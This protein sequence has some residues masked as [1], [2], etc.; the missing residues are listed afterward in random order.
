[1][2][3]PVQNRCDQTFPQIF[4]L[5]DGQS[6]PWQNLLLPSLQLVY[7]A[8]GSAF[9]II[10]LLCNGVFRVIHLNLFYTQKGVFC[11]NLLPFS[12]LIMTCSVCHCNQKHDLLKTLSFSDVNQMFN[13]FLFVCLFCGGSSWDSEPFP[14]LQTGHCSMSF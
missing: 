12:P 9:K 4:V 11:Q 14:F 6:G 1:M 7:C 2:K 8:L 10:I 13:S 3:I 5:V